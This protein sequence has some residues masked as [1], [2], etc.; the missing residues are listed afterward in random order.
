[1]GLLS[2][3][4]DFIHLTIRV[5]GFYVCAVYISIPFSCPGLLQI[6]KPVCPFPPIPACFVPPL[7]LLRISDVP[8][9]QPPPP[10]IDSNSSILLHN[11]NQFRSSQ[12]LH[13]GSLLDLS[14]QL[15]WMEAL[16]IIQAVRVRRPF[17]PSSGL[18]SLEWE[19]SVVVL[20]LELK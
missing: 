18:L 7:P 14:F 19:V 15:T 11:A 12:F 10:T 4:I 6:A 13:D 8:A 17:Q 9:S 3:F 20:F 1:M 5:L 16:I 2:G